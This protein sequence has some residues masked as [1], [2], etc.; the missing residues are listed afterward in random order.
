MTLILEWTPL[1]ENGLKEEARR[2]GMNPMEYARKL[3]EEALPQSNQEQEQ[4]ESPELRERRL[5][6]I[7]ALS[8]RTTPRQPSADGWRRIVGQFD[9]D[10][11]IKEISEEGRRIRESESYSIERK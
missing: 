6:Q 10:P 8:L 4:V 7:E 2:R 5:Q 1:V 3:I 11:I 9:N